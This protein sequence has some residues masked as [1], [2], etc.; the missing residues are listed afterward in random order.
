MVKNYDTLIWFYIIFDIA[1]HTYTDTLSLGIEA[2]VD[3]LFYTSASYPLS[4]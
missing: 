1:T 4:I 2:N 3:T